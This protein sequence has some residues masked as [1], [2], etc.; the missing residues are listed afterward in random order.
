MDFI[1][2]L[3]M[4]H[5]KSVIL[6][7]VDRLSK[8]AHFMALSHPFSASQV[9][10][11][12]TAYHPQI[13]AKQ[14][15]CVFP[16][17]PIHIPYV[18][19]DCKVETLDRTL[20]AREEMVSLLRFHLKRSQDRMKYQA[21]KHRTDKQFEVEDWVY[22]KLQPHRQV[23][24]R[25]GHQHTLSPNLQNVMEK[26]TT[27]ESWEDGLLEYKSMAILERRLGK[28][29]NR[30]VMFVLTQWTNRPI[31]EAT[32]EIYA[33]LIARFL[34]FDSAPWGQEGFQGE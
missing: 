12:S 33:D 16:N 26:I 7:V 13:D 11:L 3:R 4:S 27:W 30:S 19:G 22:L 5:G 28:Q 6:V 23:S 1:E 25:Q 21:N 24:I 14:R 8:Y 2:K 17:T 32:W 29:N 34:G 9:A 10:Q 15:C 31:E 18:P 20:Q